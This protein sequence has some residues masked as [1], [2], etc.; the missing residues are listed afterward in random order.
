MSAWL[1]E[2]IVQSEATDPELEARFVHDWANEWL[3]D[4]VTAL[5]VLAA[6]MADALRY[7]APGEAQ[8]SR[9]HELL[10]RLDALRPKDTA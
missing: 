10:A 7:P 6:D 3:V 8:R 2:I 5:A 9:T 4:H 1:R